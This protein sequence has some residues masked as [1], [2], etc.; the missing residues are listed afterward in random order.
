MIRDKYLRALE[1]SDTPDYD[2]TETFHLL[3]AASEEGDCRAKY[4]IATW[5][6]NGMPGAVEKDEAAGFKLLKQLEKSNIAEAILDLAV[7]Y[8]LGKV[9]RRNEKR[10]F[11]LYM[12]A[13]LLG[14]A[15]ACEQISQFYEEGKIVLHDAKLRDAWSIRAQ[16][17]EASISPPYRERL[18]P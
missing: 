16:Q 14:D 6:L 1:L 9:V 15:Q 7:A 4:A 11:S 3:Q 18:R 10:A 5:L 2:T 13:A 8:D 17:V 12:R